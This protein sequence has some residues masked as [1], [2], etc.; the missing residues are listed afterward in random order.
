MTSA[1][2]HISILAPLAGAIACGLMTLLLLMD[3]ESRKNWIA[4]T[5]S[6]IS[7]AAAMSLIFF[8]S[9]QSPGTKISHAL[10]WIDSFGIVY[11]MGVD[12]SNAPVL[13]LLAIVFPILVIRESRSLGASSLLLALQG[14]LCG[15]LCSQDLFVTFFFW[16]MSALPIY[17]LL[18]VWGG[19][20]REAVGFRYLMTSAV[21]N[22]LFLAG[23]L[24]IYH[25]ADPGTF[26]M[27]ELLG[28]K[29][30]D[31]SFVVLGAQM[32]VSRVAFLLCGL[33]FL[34]RVCVWPFHGWFTLLAREASPTLLVAVCGLAMPVSVNVFSRIA[35]GVFPAETANSSTLFLILGSMNCLFGAICA[36]NAPSLRSFLAYVTIFQSGM[37]IVGVGSLDSAG[38]VGAVFLQLAGGLAL[39][40]LGLASGVV[41]GRPA[42]LQQVAAQAPQL[43]AVL[44]LLLL[45][46]IGLPGLG[47]FVGSAMILSGGYTVSPWVLALLTLA[48]LMLVFGSFQ[49][50]MLLFSG[51]AEAKSAASTGSLEL[52]F[53][54]RATLFPV[55]VATIVLGVFPKPILDLI[56]PAITTLISLAK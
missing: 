41:S 36:A 45:A 29:I 28:G 4:P 25:A 53:A 17:F 40:G 49:V 27:S 50:L 13:L 56:K 6:L 20:G 38:F 37:L 23:I 32:N 34:C 48:A 44:A 42:G 47:G 35:Y 11:E 54:E 46:A 15:L 8:L 18:A 2:I 12:G 5:V 52:T 22:A 30:Q 51:K 31:S 19:A 21:G 1:L 7:S 24:L 43:A 16:S 33:G 26:V 9:Q 10:P 39:S 55:V 3:A 14:A